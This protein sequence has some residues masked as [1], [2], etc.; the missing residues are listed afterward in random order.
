M[1]TRKSRSQSEKDCELWLWA[2][3]FTTQEKRRTDRRWA[4]EKP[5]LYKPSEN[6]GPG[7]DYGRPP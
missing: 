4:G 6:P 7:A 1:R 5:P 3:V 2:A